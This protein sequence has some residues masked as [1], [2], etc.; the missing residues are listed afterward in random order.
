MQIISKAKNRLLPKN[1][2]RWFRERESGY[3]L[4]RG[5]NLM[6]SAVR[7]TLKSMC[8][9]VNGVRLWNNLPEN[10]K[11]SNSLAQVK[12]LLKKHFENYRE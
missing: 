12:N 5:G 4:R 6:Q 1:V 11:A 2:E 8:I 7:T 9:S 3:N 10:I